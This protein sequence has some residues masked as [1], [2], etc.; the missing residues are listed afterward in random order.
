MEVCSGLLSGGAEILVLGCTELPPAFQMLSI[1]YP[2]V[3]PTLVL[4]RSAIRFAG[5]EFIPDS[6]NEQI[7]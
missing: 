2:H 4:A 1:H 3:D 6:S 5:A 7:V